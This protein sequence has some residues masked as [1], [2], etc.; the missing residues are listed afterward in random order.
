MGLD[1]VLGGERGHVRDPLQFMRSALLITG[2]E[3]VGVFAGV[4]FDDRHAETQSGI[5]LALLRLDEQ[6]DADV[7]FA[8]AIDDGGEGVV[9]ARRVQP[10][11]GRALLA[12]FRD[13]AGGVRG[14]GEGD[15]QHLVGGGH[16]E[17]EGEVGRVLNAFQIR[18]ADMAPILAQMGGNPVTPDTRHDLRRAHGIGM[19]PPARIADGGDVVDVDAQTQGG[20][21]RCVHIRRG[22]RAWSRG[23][24]RVRGALRPLRRSGS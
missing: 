10:A 14:M 19:V 7:G 11:F 20:A 18:I 9:Q 23:W 3:R 21:M 16:F 6:R 22:C 2:F 8:Q 5:Q 17:I 4:E 15:R 24:R 12:F 13:D 1:P